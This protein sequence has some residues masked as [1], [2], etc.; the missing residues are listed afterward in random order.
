[1]KQKIALIVLC[2]TL[3]GCLGSAAGIATAA[4]IDIIKVPF[5]VAGA[6]AGAAAE[7]AG[8]MVAERSGDDEG[9]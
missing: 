8:A 5:K 4:A 3:N 1:M 9:S 7:A 2:F 6:V